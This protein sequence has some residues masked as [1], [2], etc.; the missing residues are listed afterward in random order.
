MANT[1]S[2]EEKIEMQYDA[3][4]KSAFGK[5]RKCFFRQLSRQMDKQTLFSDMDADH[6]ESIADGYAIKAFDDI[7][8]EFQVMQYSVFVH[9]DLLHNALSQ[10]DHRTRDIVLLAFWMEMTDREI[11]DETGIPR[12]TVNR[13]RNNAYEKLRKVLEDEG[14][15][16]RNFFSVRRRTEE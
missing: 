8:A 12:R 9:D 11:A 16:A 4:I 2:Y 15:D 5:E 3:F 6:I 7:E 13:I 10:L 14:Y 1:P